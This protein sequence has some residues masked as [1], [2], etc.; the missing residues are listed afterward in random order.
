MADEEVT[1]KREDGI[2]K[3][4]SNTSL[5]GEGI[6]SREGSP[7]DE[8]PDLSEAV[9]DI[10]GPPPEEDIPSQTSAEDIPAVK[11][12]DSAVK[13]GES[14]KPPRVPTVLLP[15]PSP[16]SRNTSVGH[17]RKQSLGELS[18]LTDYDAGGEAID[19]AFRHSSISWEKEVVPQDPNI[20]M[21]MFG[22]TM[23]ASKPAPPTSPTISATPPT[24]RAKKNWAKVKKSVVR[25][26]DINARTVNP[27]ETEAERAI[28]RA[29]EST[30][31]RNAAKAG[32]ILP[33]V[34]DEAAAMFTT[35]KKDVTPEQSNVSASRKSSGG[36]ERSMMSGTTSSVSIVKKGHLRTK[37]LDNKLFDLATEMTK[38]QQQDDPEGGGRERTL[39][40]DSGGGNRPRLFSGEDLGLTDYK[41]NSGDVLVQNAAAL[42]RR[43]LAAK[44]QTSSGTSE[45][46]TPESVNQQLDNS[47]GSGGGRRNSLVSSQK[48][49]GSYKKMHEVILEA[50]E[51]DESDID[52]EVGVGVSADAAEGTLVHDDGKRKRFGFRPG[53]MMKATNDEVKEDFDTFRRFLHPRTGVIKFYL[54]FVVCCIIGPGIVV[55]AI[56]FHSGNPGLGREGATTR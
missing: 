1:P 30:R 32:N 7:F 22:E 31:R 5:I 29:L 46:S 50:G 38:M 15:R 16:P 33:H 35:S 44:R 9:D 18:A 37:T 25:Q 42:F 17:S 2:P 48:S 10:P 34:S 47:Q 45:G 19:L 23:D 49:G 53:K 43:P 13:S 51:S 41:G 36:D 20:V 21:P 8:A 40:A 28:L 3:N 55:A 26:E 4:M 52:L 6:P 12:S 54:L 27:F 24:A 56:L 14:G 39:T 11:S